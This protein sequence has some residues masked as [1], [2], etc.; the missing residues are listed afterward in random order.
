MLYELHEAQRS[1]IVPFVDFAQVA[2]RLYG[3]VPHAQPL[4]AGYDLLYRLGKDYE[5]PEFGIKTVKVGD[6]DVVIHESIEV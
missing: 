5:K 6:R 2:A 1:L 3:Q 4:A